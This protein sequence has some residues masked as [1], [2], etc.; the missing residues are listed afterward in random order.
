[1]DSVFTSLLSW[2]TILF[3]LGIHFVTYILRTVIEVAVPKVK[4][5]DT[6]LY[7]LWRELVLPLGPFA[8]GFALVFVAKKFP[9]PTPIATI[10]S[11]KILYALCCGGASGWLYARIRAWTEGSN[12][13]SSIQGVL[14]PFGVSPSK[15]PVAPPPA[16]ATPPAAPPPANPPTAKT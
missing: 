9:W 1:M 3:C 4:V 8:V 13:P 15:P 5:P 2:Q 11:A 7:K 14:S 12:L 16:P 10:T 6:L